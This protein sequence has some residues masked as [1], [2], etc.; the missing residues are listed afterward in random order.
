MANLTVYQIN[1]DDPE[2]EPNPLITFLDV[3]EEW[4][5]SIM[6]IHNDDIDFNIQ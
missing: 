3:P 5:A 2:G 6:A 4:A 1:R